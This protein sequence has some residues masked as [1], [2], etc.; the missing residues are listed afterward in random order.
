MKIGVVG[1]AGAFGMKHLNAVGLID[2]VGVYSVVG[3]NAEA[4]ASFAEEQNI[5]HSS[6]SLD[7][8]LKISEIEAVILCTPTQMHASQAIQCLEAGKHVMVE[9]PMADN[10][11]DS[12][13][14]AEV[15]QK[16]DLIA[17]AGHTR[18]FNPCTSGST[19][20]CNREN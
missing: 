5:A 2:A 11:E 4:M 10:I 17:M 20:R 18:R 9:I 3:S 8:T 1:A 14:L 16:T 7:E 13:K 15:R 12:R 19:I 6:D